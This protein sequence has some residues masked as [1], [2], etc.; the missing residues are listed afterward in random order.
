[1]SIAHFYHWAH[2]TDLGHFMRAVSWAFSVCETL[3]FIGLCMLLGALLVIDL[4]ILGFYRQISINA[5]MKLIP[6]A[7]A[8]FA[9]NLVTGIC[10]FASDSFN[11][12]QNPMFI[13]KMGL[14][15]L[16]GI[17]AIYHEVACKAGLCGLPKGVE[18]DR[19]A[20]FVAASSL[21]LWIL[22]ITAGRLLPQFG[23]EG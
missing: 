1:M 21:V 17:N 15:V 11:Y 20:K 8:G 10:F 14:V 4:R 16:A 9:I 13:F 2:D 19:T 7:I 18:P 6:L 22:V 5:A 23:I 3:H 12:G